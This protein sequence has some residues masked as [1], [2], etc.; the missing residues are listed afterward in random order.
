[1]NIIKAENFKLKIFR[2]NFYYLFYGNYEDREFIYGMNWEYS[3]G[4]TRRRFILCDIK[5]YNRVYHRGYGIRDLIR[6]V[7]YNLNSNQ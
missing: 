6:N 3:Y 5:N 4:E 7:Y 1:M 2:D